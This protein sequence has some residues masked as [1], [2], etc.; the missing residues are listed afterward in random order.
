M[1]L[2]IQENGYLLQNFQVHPKVVRANNAFI[3]NSLVTVNGFIR[4]Q[5]FQRIKKI[6][7]S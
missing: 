4:S 1:D 7:R 5:E 3:H 6:N 2:E